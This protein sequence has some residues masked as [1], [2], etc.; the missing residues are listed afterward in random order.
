[1]KKSILL[2]AGIIV[3]GAAIVFLSR[4]GKTTVSIDTGRTAPP[5][6][7]PARR[8]DPAVVRFGFEISEDLAADADVYE[9][10]LRY[11]QRK[12]GR[13]F[14]LRFVKKGERLIDNL[15]TG[16]VDFAVV[17]AFTYISDRKR[18]KPLLLARE[19]DAQGKAEFRSAIVVRPDSPIMTLADLRGKSFTFGRKNS[20][21]QHVIPFIMLFNAGINLGDLKNHTFGGTSRMAVDMVLANASDAAGM[22]ASK[23]LALARDNIIRI[24]ALSNGYPSNVVLA[25]RKVDS[26]LATA[27][28]NALLEMKP[29]GSDRDVLNH[30]DGTD[31]P[32]G[33]LEAYPSQYDVYEGMAAL[34]GLLSSGERP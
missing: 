29:L 15:G 7:I 4:S 31:A 30:W 13:P 32:G 5:G 24:V 19:A 18:Y 17:G 9:S 28:K 23:A 8:K 12:V 10:F 2:A 16:L 34:Y 6:S 3:V 11:L 25:S 26:G 1:M 20:T 33:Y 14:D 22:P 27:V 21:R